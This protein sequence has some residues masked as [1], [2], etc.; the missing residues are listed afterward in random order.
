MKAEQYFEKADALYDGILQTHKDIRKNCETFLKKV[1]KEEGGSIDLTDFESNISV[2]YDGGNHPEY[3]SNAFSIVEG[4]Y[5][6]EKGNIVLQTEDCSEY[7]IE[8]I[9][10]SEVYDVAAFV[11]EYIDGSL[12]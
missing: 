11:R 2:T 9:N 10:W 3:A 1:L 8:N 12:S 5:L 4:V 6:D 7:P